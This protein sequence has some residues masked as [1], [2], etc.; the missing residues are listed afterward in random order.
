[1]KT[2]SL[3]LQLG[4]AAAVA[5]GVLA[6]IPSTATAS[7]NF[8]CRMQGQWLDNPNDVFEFDAAY[9]Y[10]NG[11]DDFKGLYDN[12]GQAKAQ[13]DG[14]ARNGVWLIQLTYLDDKHKGMIK[15]LV[16]KGSKDK[17][18]HE[19]VVSGDYKTFLGANDIKHAGQ[20][21]LEG[22]CK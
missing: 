19:I 11:E 9:V 8:V 20:F 1:M 17:V 22:R 7:T 12:P 15:K 3:V 2:R 18:T 16:G 4:V 13:I 21:R 14:A 6:A 10:N 5:T